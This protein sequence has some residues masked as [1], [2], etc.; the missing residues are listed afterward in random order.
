[1]SAT[2]GRLAVICQLHGEG[3]RLY[4]IYFRQNDA[5]LLVT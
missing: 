5:N 2:L 4:V 3:W 1:M